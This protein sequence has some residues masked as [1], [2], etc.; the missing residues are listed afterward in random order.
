MRKCRECG[1]SELNACVRV[2]GR[3]ERVTCSWVEEDLCS[4]CSPGAAL[5]D[6]KHP[7]GAMRRSRVERALAVVRRLPTPPYRI[8]KF[9]RS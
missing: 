6:W 8:G 1:C 3:H 2:N 9:G 4:A 7:P 5:L